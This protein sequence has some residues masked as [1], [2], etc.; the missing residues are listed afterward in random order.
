MVQALGCGVEG[1]GPGHEGER[2]G[3]RV[4]AEALGLRLAP[5]LLRGLD[6]GVQVEGFGLVFRVEL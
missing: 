5:C 6:F 4:R 1:A 3:A 2:Q